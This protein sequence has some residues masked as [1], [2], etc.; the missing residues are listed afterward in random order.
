[1]CAKTKRECEIINPQV[2]LLAYGA[3]QCSNFQQPKT[4]NY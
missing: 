2:G 3:V 4:V 1:M